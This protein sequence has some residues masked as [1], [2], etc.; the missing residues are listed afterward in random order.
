MKFLPK[1]IK[2]PMPS[3]SS[4][5]SIK[6]ISFGKTQ[7]K[8]QAHSTSFIHL[9]FYVREDWWGNFHS[10]AFGIPFITWLSV[11]HFY[12]QDSDVIIFFAR[13]LS[14]GVIS[15]FFLL[16][17]VPILTRRVWTDE[18]S[19]KRFYLSRNSHY[20]QVQKNFDPTREGV[21]LLNHKKYL[22]Q[23]T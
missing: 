5:F 10:D 11:A 13:I 17:I 3:L 16:M 23:R 1:K 4:L 9:S 6:F 7:K 15:G 22:K 2:L 21:D 19:I 8:T 12:T 18:D 20:T 14:V